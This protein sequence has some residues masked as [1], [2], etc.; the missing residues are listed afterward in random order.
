MPS[1][2]SGQI[3]LYLHEFL[4]VIFGYSKADEAVSTKEASIDQFEINQ[5]DER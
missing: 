2:R 3:I 1:I 4:D 5:R